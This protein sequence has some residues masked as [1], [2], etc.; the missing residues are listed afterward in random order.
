MSKIKFINIL[1]AALI[2]G[3]A[4]V[5][6]YANS[7]P[8]LWQQGEMTF[9]SFFWSINGIPDS[10]FDESPRSKDYAEHVGE[11]GQ[12]FH[13]RQWT[14]VLRDSENSAYTLHTG[15]TKEDFLKLFAAR[16]M[17]NSFR[18]RQFSDFI[19]M[20]SFK[21]WQGLELATF[22]NYTLIFIH[23]INALLLYLVIKH[24]TASA[25]TAGIG[26]L[27]FLNSGV[28][29]TTLIFPFRTAKLLVMTF[30]LV[31]LNMILSA[32]GK[33]ADPSFFKKFVFFSIFIFSFFTDE[34]AILTAPAVLIFMAQREGGKEFLS[35]KMLWWLFFT[36][37][38]IVGFSVFAYFASKSFDQGVNFSFQMEHLRDLASYWRDPSVVADTMRAFFLFFLRR[39]FGYWDFSFWGI[40]AFFAFAAVGIFAI[41]NLKRWP[42]ADRKIIFVFVALIAAKAFLIPHTNGV[43]RVIMPPE[44]KFPSLLFFSYYYTYFDSLLLC[45]IFGLLLKQFLVSKEKFLIVLIAVGI[46]SLSNTA[47]LKDGPGDSLQFMMWKQ[48]HKWATEQI[49][50]VRSFLQKKNT[51]PV[52]L[53]FPTMES[54][55]FKVSYNARETGERFYSAC[56]LSM[57]LRALEDG[58]AIVSLW[59]ARP[60]GLPLSV[61]ELS[62]AKSFLDIPSGEL[63]D[64]KEL[65][66]SMMAG[67][68]RPRMIRAPIK[69]ITVDVPAAKA[70]KVLFFIKGYA[71]FSLEAGGKFISGGQTYGYAYQV[72]KY[73]FIDNETDISQVRLT[74]RPVGGESG[75]C[76]V[77]PVVLKEGEA[78]SASPNTK[79]VSL[80]RTSTSSFEAPK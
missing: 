79:H 10:Y 50:R 64:L 25:M 77:G 39:N 78:G 12:N 53:S 13:E 45:L 80:R 46:V 4:A 56:V 62:A 5:F 75:A 1:I 68:M 16:A 7:R 52:Y 67:D 63:I 11:G 33:L 31:Q 32:R 29:I 51:C 24:L 66:N 60:K 54:A 3:H 26:V 74:L 57:Y 41:S 30:F 47:H 8:I 44:T 48:N 20:V 27:L 19:D 65:Q 21:F 42:P 38:A 71:E 43:H 35:R 6:F 22:R 28:A 15:I 23:L 17:E 2:A 55:V 14:K 9:K 69:T 40:L 49:T 73:D 70:R 37:T 61:D 72:F 59:N 18:F 76:V 36:V 58:R 34:L